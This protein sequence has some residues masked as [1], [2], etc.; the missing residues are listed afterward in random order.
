MANLLLPLS[1]YTA[2]H[3]QLKGFEVWDSACTVWAPRGQQISR[4]TQ[5]VESKADL[6]SSKIKFFKKAVGTHGLRSKAIFT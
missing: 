3:S 1:V 2:S 4:V 6:Q 5:D